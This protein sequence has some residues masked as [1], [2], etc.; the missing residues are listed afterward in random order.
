MGYTGYS[1]EDEKNP[2]YGT[3]TLDHSSLILTFF[4]EDYMR[5]KDCTSL[6]ITL[7]SA[8]IFKKTKK[9]IS[10]FIIINRKNERL[11]R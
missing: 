9:V 2:V 6:K 5:Y 1:I 7:Q 4:H 8:Q 11:L 3:A 10:D